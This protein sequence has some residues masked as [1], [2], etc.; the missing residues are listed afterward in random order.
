MPMQ[1]LIGNWKGSEERGLGGGYNGKRGTVVER[2]KQ[3][4]AE[5]KRSWHK[6]S[7]TMINQN[8]RTQLSWAE[9]FR[10]QWKAK[11]NQVNK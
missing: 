8:K 10:E 2:D 4:K 5:V 3:G 1:R 6:V 11:S 7:P 9:R